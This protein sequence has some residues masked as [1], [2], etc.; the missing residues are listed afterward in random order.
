MLTK[1]IRQST[2]SRQPQRDTRE[3]SVRASNQPPPADD[4]SWTHKHLPPLTRDAVRQTHVPRIIVDTVR[5]HAKNTG[6][7]GRPL[8]VLD[9]GCGQGLLVASLLST[10]VEAYGV[11]INANY[12][13]TGRPYFERE[14]RWHPNRLSL[15]GEDGRTVFEDGFFDIIVS[16]QVCEH[17]TDIDQFLSEQHRL[18]KPNGIALHILPARW[19]VFESHIGVPFAHWPGNPRW[20]RALIRSWLRLIEPRA[21]RASLRDR[22]RRYER[23]LE[24]QTHYRTWAD[25][26]AAFAQHGFSADAHT[27][28][29]HKLRLRAPRLAALLN[30]LPAADRLFTRVFTTFGMLQF[31]AMPM[32]RAVS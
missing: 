24:E 25:L 9:F 19:H 29:M 2:Q 5:R 27:A 13:A 31:Y 15:I 26:L 18:L 7:E 21:S 6:N 23:Y 11:D 4:S 10:G 28:T 14:G 1:P 8:R 17:V 12:L 30:R 32:P 20:R 22:A 3:V 16:D